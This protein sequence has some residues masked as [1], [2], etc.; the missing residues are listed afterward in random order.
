[1][2]P[3]RS[4]TRKFEGTESGDLEGR[5]MVLIE[6]AIVAQ[7]GSSLSGPRP[8][9]RPRAGFLNSIVDR[10][11]DRQFTVLPRPCQPNRRSRTACGLNDL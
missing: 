7:E 4:G 11:V 8:R 3:D 5:T 6:F 1:M 9:R 2:R 10:G